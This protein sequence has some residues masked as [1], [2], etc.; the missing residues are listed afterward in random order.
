MN[1]GRP[2]DYSVELADALC[3]RISNGE[4]LRAICREDGMP[5]K[6]TV[7]RWLAAEA[8][9]ATKYAHAREEQADLHAEAIVE[10]SDEVEIETTYKGEEVVLELSS[11]AVAR[12]RL[13]VDARKWYAAKLA[14]KKYGDKIQTEHSGSIGLTKQLSN[15]E[16]EAIA[17]GSGG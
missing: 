13:R 10:I 9:F 4:S 11:A 12:N 16:L 5:N 17:A 2:S 6:S 14:P 8:D 7:F 1:A 15:A 3:E